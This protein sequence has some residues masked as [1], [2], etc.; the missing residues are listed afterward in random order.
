MPVI[1]LLIPLSVFSLCKDFLP[2]QLQL[3]NH[4]QGY[5]HVRR[6]FDHL[7][8]LRYEGSSFWLPIRLCDL[9]WAR[10]LKYEEAYIINHFHFS[11]FLL[12]V[13]PLNPARNALCSSYACCKIDF[14]FTVFEQDSAISDLIQVIVLQSEQSGFV[15]EQSVCFIE[16]IVVGIGYRKKINATPFLFFIF[17]VQFNHN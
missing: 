2:T 3:P 7:L 1:C 8:G 15:L 5:R 10:G 12:F 17:G 9:G 14:I 11:L 6:I 13:I 4:T 16:S